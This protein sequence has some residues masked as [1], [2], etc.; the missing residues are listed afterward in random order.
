MVLDAGVP[1]ERQTQGCSGA[2]LS[3]GVSGSA[4]AGCL[5]LL[6]L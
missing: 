1:R 5:S 3:P 4:F 2:A 6:V